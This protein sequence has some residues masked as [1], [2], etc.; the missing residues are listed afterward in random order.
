MNN[1][2]IIIKK[3]KTFRDI[4]TSKQYFDNWSRYKLENG[5]LTHVKGRSLSQKTIQYI[6]DKEKDK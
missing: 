6:L 5:Q 4:F 3:F 2:E 1:N